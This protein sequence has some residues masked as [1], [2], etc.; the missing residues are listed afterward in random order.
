[1]LRM[2][3]LIK[4]GIKHWLS[5]FPSAHIL[6]GGDF[7]ITLYSH[8]DRWPPGRDSS[9]ATKIKSLIDGYGLED[10]WRQ[11]CPNDPGF[12][13]SIMNLSNY[14]RIDYWLVSKD[15]NQDDISISTHP[16]PLTDHKAI[17]IQI[18]ICALK[19]EIAR[20]SYWKLNI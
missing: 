8:I 16:T 14:S 11:K 10:T 1:M 18:N 19:R 12:I 7:N 13:W 2:L 4:H 9:V 20:T 6:I 5:K 3:D 15:L 17:L